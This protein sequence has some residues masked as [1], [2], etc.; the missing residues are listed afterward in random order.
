[1]II[2]KTLFIIPLYK[3]NDNSKKVSS[4]KN[5]HDYLKFIDYLIHN[6]LIANN[7][8]YKVYDN[9]N[10][11]FKFNLFNLDNIENIILF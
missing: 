1:M 3:I 4:E 11:E 5:F 10:K 7:Y 9:F 8:F 6:N 2:F